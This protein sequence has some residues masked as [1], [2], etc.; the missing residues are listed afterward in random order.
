LESKKDGSFSTSD[1]QSEVEKCLGGS[2][3]E[4]KR[5]RL[6]NLGDVVMN[7]EIRAIPYMSP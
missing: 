3:R 1:D 7:H 2:L 4:D 6:I 5:G